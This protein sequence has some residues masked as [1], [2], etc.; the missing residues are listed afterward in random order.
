MAPLI[1]R[2]FIFLALIAACGRDNVAPVAAP[3]AKSVR[4]G[5]AILRDPRD[6]LPAGFVGNGLRCVSCH[7]DDGT[8]AFAMPWVGVYGRFPQYRSRS[9]NVALIEDRVN[10]CLRR[11]MNGKPLPFESNDMRD[12]VAYMSSLSRGTVMGR[13]ETG[14]GID[15][16]GPLQPDTAHGRIAF[17]L[18]CAR[19][20]G[21]NG[22]GIKAPT[23]AL[24]G[25]PLWGP[26]SF[27]IGSGMAR[28]RVSA[29]FTRR[30]MPLDMPGTLDAQTAFDIAG[31]LAT[32]PRPDFPEK[33]N[34]WPNGDAPPDVTYPTTAARARSP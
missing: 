6:S 31:F 30:N 19:C 2:R 25:A 5:L 21:P 26:E 10:D 24:S 34:D 29:A 14:A 13:R 3:V 12:I 27:N 17:A 32:R 20:H 23:P 16:I 11:S 4:R 7:L 8:R 28:I 9:G 22:Q 18:N 15:S 1:W 33:A